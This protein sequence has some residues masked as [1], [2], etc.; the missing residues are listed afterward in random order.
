MKRLIQRNAVELRREAFR[1]RDDESMET[2]WEIIDS[3]QRQG[4]DIGDNGR[5]ELA[6]REKI[7]ETYQKK[8]IRNDNAVIE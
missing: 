3:L 7:K 4:I 5:R 6:E 1:A 8:L 2:I